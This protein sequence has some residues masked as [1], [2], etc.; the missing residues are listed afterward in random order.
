[1]RAGNFIHMHWTWPAIVF[2]LMVSLTVAGCADA[3]AAAHSNRVVGSTV[4]PWPALAWQTVTLP[5][6]IELA[7]FAHQPGG[8]Q[9]AISPADGHDAWLCA[10][11]TTPGSFAIWATTDAGVTWR[12]VGTLAPSTPM[13]PSCAL[14]PDDLDPAMLAAVISWGAGADGTLR[15]ASWLSSNGGATWHALPGEVQSQAISSRNG[16][17]YAILNDTSAGLIAR[18]GQS[19]AI[20]TDGLRTWRRV[21]PSGITPGDI[22]F[23]LWVSPTTPE[24]LV[25]T[26][27][28]TLWHSADNGATWTH[29]STPAMQITFGAWIAAPPHWLLCGF[30]E[31]PPQIPCSADVG[32]TWTEYP[33]LTNTYTCASCG[34]WGAPSGGT[35]HCFTGVIAPDGALLFACAPNGTVPDSTNFALYRLAPGSSTWTVLGAAPGPWLTAPTVGPLWCWNAQFG[36]LVTTAMPER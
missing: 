20:S 16:V 34:K 18:P 4:T 11:S 6:S 13:P 32:A 9:F 35:D 21:R 5:P 22:I 12:Q 25:A 29:A 33:Q 3:P 1:M 23:Q 14:Q 28:N 15:A 7:S 30:L 24:I 31:T 10:S 19:I 8:A 36:T 17:T 27:D 2:A 26:E